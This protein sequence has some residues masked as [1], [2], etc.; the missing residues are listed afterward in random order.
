MATPGESQTSKPSSQGKVVLSNPK[1]LSALHGH[2]FDR[3][4]TKY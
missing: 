2:N 3:C 1:P 4:I